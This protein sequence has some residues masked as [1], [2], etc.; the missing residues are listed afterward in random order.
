[1]KINVLSENLSSRIAAGEVVERP[2]SVVKELVENSIDA[3]STKVFIEIEN[4]GLE[5]IKITDNG[6]GIPSSDLPVAFE[7]FATSKIDNSSDL[8]SIQ[9]L[10]FRGEALPSIASVSIVNAISKTK[11][12]NM[13]SVFDSEFLNEKKIKRISCNTGTSISVMKLFSNVPA[14]LKFIKSANSEVLKIHNLINYFSLVY[15]NIDFQ[16]ITDGKLKLDTTG[17]SNILDIYK[18]IYGIYSKNNLLLIDDENESSNYKISGLIGS[19]SMYKSNRNYLILSVNGRIINSKK[20]NYAVERS[21]AGLLPQRKFPMG[22]IRITAPLNQ[23]DPNVHPNKAEVRFIN[24]DYVFSMIQKNIRNTIS[25]RSPVKVVN[26][27]EQN[28]YDSQKNINLFSSEKSDFIEK[29]F[30]GL[31]DM[32]YSQNEYS[33]TMKNT[34]PILRVIGQFSKKY[35]ACEGPN[36]LYVLDQHAAHERVKYEQIF[37]HLSKEKH[38]S[39]QPL[40]D[41]LIIEVN[42][43]TTSILSEYKNELSN[44]GWQV[45]AFGPTSLA[46]REVPSIITK[47]NI[48]LVNGNIQSIFQNLLDE[49]IVLSDSDLWLDKIVASLSCHSAVRAGQI[50]SLDEQKN[51]IKM[52]EK[53]D[54]PQTCPHGRP[55]VMQIENEILDSE[56]LRK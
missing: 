39:S 19:P 54:S 4:G 51:I 46:I 24:E 50:L 52:L 44:C 41:P 18:M 3:N 40:L 21:F 55:T 2:F 8:T 31:E 11:N 29:K 22:I 56:F 38:L 27:N 49:V 1:M 34:I 14:R 5:L 26:Q 32:I 12:E 9:T 20:L 13:G 25:F 35:I 17:S 7:R 36:G 37:N 45:D 10:G 33:K 47:N 6:D 48:S 30:H 28:L 16:L 15:P 23:V 43:D 42:N 53:C